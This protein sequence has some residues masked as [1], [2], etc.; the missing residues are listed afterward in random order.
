MRPKFST[1]TGVTTSAIVA[2]LVF[3]SIVVPGPLTDV[4][5][6]S[7]PQWVAAPNALVNPFAG[8]GTG[9]VSP[10]S[11]GEFPG[12]DVPF[13]MLQWSPDTAPAL[14]TGASYSYDESRI[15]GFSLTHLSGS[16]CPAYQD[17]PVLPTVGRMSAAPSKAT[18]TFSHTGESAAPGRYSV[19]LGPSRVNVDLTVTARTGLAKFTFPKDTADNLLFKV[20]G[21]ANPVSASAVRVIGRNEL[22]GQVTS[23]QFCQTGTSYT[24]FFVAE[25]S[26]DFVRE[27]TWTSSSVI[28]GSD[29]CLAT[30]GGAY[31]TFKDRSTNVVR[32]K[33]GISYV[34]TADAQSNLAHED[35]GWSLQSVEHQARREW[36]ALLGRIRIAGGTLTEQRIF[37][38]A[39]YHSLLFPSLISD[40]NGEYTGDDDQVHYSARPQYSNFSEWDI[41]RSEIELLALVAPRQTGDMIQSLVNDAEQ[42]GWLPKWAIADGDASQM[43]GDSADPII[44]SA[45]AFGARDF[46][47]EGALA[48]M[49]KGATETESNHGLEIER[50]YL[51]QYLTQHYVNAGSLDLTSINYSIG[52]SATLEYAL[53]DFSIAQFAQ[54]LGDQSVYTTM[55][56]SAHNWEYLFDPATGYVQARNSDGS[57]P[58]GPAFQSDLFEPG[59][60]KGFEEGNAIQYTWAV[61][62]DLGALAKLMGGTSQA[63]SKLDSFFEH[64]NAGRFE[65]YD[66]AGNEPSLWTPWEYDYFGAPWRTQV[67]VRSIADTLYH[68]APVNEPGNDDLGAISSWYVWAAIGL[69]PVT[70]GTA[71]LALASPLFPDVSFE[72]P[73]GKRLVLDAPQAS[74]SDP[75]VHSVTVSGPG[76]GSLAS[77]PS[78]QACYAVTSS[79]SHKGTAAAG[80]WQ[81]PWLPAS[82][83][84]TGATLHY[85]LSGTPDR[86]W[87]TA[88]Q[89]APPSYATGAVPALGFSVPSGGTTIEQDRT[90]KAELGLQQVSQGGPGVV[91][92]ASTSPGTTVSPSAGE[93]TASTTLRAPASP[94]EQSCNSPA[95]QHTMLSLKSTTAGPATVTFSLRTTS[96]GELPPV[97]LRVTVLPQN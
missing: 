59:G 64:L 44:A 26:R 14:G 80:S 20:A 47:L 11:I 55:M 94:S 2:L 91:W 86:D 88:P 50:Q 90:S 93:F 19:K 6:A 16:G 97:V 52:G 42:N 54:S 63:V 37:Y 29:A 22:A 76:E 78:A 10:G 12:A 40:D 83:L 87:G 84:T 3:G 57:F 92:T 62:E 23:G 75:H 66:W 30:T 72:L 4:A 38:T 89:D 17:I 67:V 43:N 85:V 70:P 31:V 45:Y 18:D 33:V 81:S 56:Q 51:S 53:D 8:T 7:S 46:D 74:P 35:P 27:G 25:F 61:P 96:G 82:A 58:P 39:L 36:N 95:R 24:L 73:S 9:S 68:D 28:A 15:S 5:A 60:E 71:N 1:C 77:E 13:G 32:M 69:Y 48:A 49:V 65:P 34:S 79:H 41:Y 21:S